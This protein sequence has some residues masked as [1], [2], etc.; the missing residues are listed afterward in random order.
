MPTLQVARLA[1]G[2]KLNAK[3]PL[4]YIHKVREAYGCILTLS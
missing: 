1:Q 4:V 3:K 2:F